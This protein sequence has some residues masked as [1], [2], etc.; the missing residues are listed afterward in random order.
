MT[1]PYDLLIAKIKAVSRRW[2]VARW[3]KGLAITL[4]FALASLFLS[5]YMGRQLRFTPASIWVLRVFVI[6]STTFAAVRYLLLPAGRRVSYVQVARFIEENYPELQERLSSAVE[7]GAAPSQGP[8]ISPALTDRLIVDALENTHRID[9][10]RLIKSRD[11][12][13]FGGLSAAILFAAI[14]SLLLGPASLRYGVGKLFPYGSQAAARP[15]AYKVMVTPGDVD[16]AKG[17]DLKITAR[18]EGLVPEK[19]E[20]ISKDSNAVEWTAQAMTTDS[21]SNGFTLTLFNLTA[22]RE[23]YVSGEQ[24]QS[25]HFRITVGDIPRV[26]K[27]KTT[28]HYPPYTG[29]PEQIIENDGNLSAVKGTQVDFLAEINQSVTGARI[30]YNDGASQPMTVAGQALQA[31]IPVLKNTSYVIQV[32]DRRGKMYLASEE[33][34]IEALT[35]NP[36]T[37]AMVKPGRDRKATRLEEVLTE[38][39]AED[40]FELSNVELVYTI[41]GG[42]ETRVLL[43]EGRRGRGKKNVSATH[44]FFLED[45]RL[46]PGDFVTYYA[47]ARDGDPSPRRVARSDIY[48]L[49][50]TRT[51]KEFRQVQAADGGESEGG[52]AFRQLIQQQREVIAATWK[53]LSNKEQFDKRTYAENLRALVLTEGRLKQEAKTLAEQIK[54]RMQ[55][56]GDEMLKKLSE[57]FNQASEKMGEAESWLMKDRLTEA[58]SPERAALQ[59][60]LK[61]ESLF[62]ELQVAYG[63]S[64]S[65]NSR[66]SERLLDDLEELFTLEMDKLKNQYETLAPSRRGDR[67][68]QMDAIRRKL[69]E[70]AERQQR[71]NEQA[72]Q[73]ATGQP[74]LSGGGSGQSM[75]AQAQMMKEVEELK[76]QLERL[77]RDQPEREKRALQE[78]LEQTLTEMKK[79]LEKLRQN[80]AGAAAGS[81]ARAQQQLERAQRQLQN[82]QQGRLRDHIRAARKNMEQILDQQNQI[83]KEVQRLSRSDSAA[84]RSA[85]ATRKRLASRKENLAEQVEQAK[86]EID[87]MTQEA[88][89]GRRRLPSP[90]GDKLRQARDTLAQENLPGKIR[91]GKDRLDRGPMEQARRREHAISSALGQA[92]QRLK[93]A[94]QSAGQSEEE[95]LAE[96]L[97][98][99]RD[100]MENLSSL[101]DRVPSRQGDRLRPEGAGKAEGRR[102]AQGQPSANPSTPSPKDGQNRS[103]HDGQSAQNGS[104][105]NQNSQAPPPT[106]SPS[107]Q[108]RG[109]RGN[110]GQEPS[111]MTGTMSGSPPVGSPPGADS[112]G[113]QVERELQERIREAAELAGRIPNREL[114]AMMEQILGGMR[115]LDA[116]GAGNDP[117]FVE[118]LRTQVLDPLQRL[119][120]QISKQLGLIIAKNKLATMDEDSVP[121]EYRRWVEQYYKE[122]AERQK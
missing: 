114:R 54:Q 109:T 107:D 39:K 19:V 21:E 103:P 44:T 37:V 86:A 100:L 91:E 78:Q 46:S 9:V 95:K 12:A 4:A 104:R 43:F 17:I 57:F 93:E 61:A 118:R 7:M 70:L 98:R 64:N 41:N 16:I 33:Y 94:E 112:L 106:G 8:N 52:N 83:E 59:E 108:G 76:R 14:F 68:A 85:E 49:D 111:P 25:R 6:L 58:L 73:L 26:E 31:R 81:G 84:T 72:L 75:Q 113:R 34:R 3:L 101:S 38:V 60:L 42:Q 15:T 92:L 89:S 35:D 63:S 40:D 110:Q 96:A 88:Q 120:L 11:L 77:S 122:L 13:A 74:A 24:I 18:F 23:Y 62:K 27:I 29:L 22:S 32:T 97:S 115:R 65:P 119:E 121:E 55:V 51:D 2:R 47:Q 71:I 45:M 82:T 20:L 99:T 28:Y 105:R 80:D 53:V 90:V 69:K 117:Q 102:P 30:L 116:Q 36:P 67:D 10:R 56:F 5:V 79:S 1:Q 66:S 50:I 48:F 87:R